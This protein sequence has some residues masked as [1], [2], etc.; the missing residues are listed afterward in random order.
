M[1]E[2]LRRFRASL[3][4][5][6]THSGG[7]TLFVEQLEAR[8]NPTT[9]VTSVVASG[10]AITAG[11]GDLRAGQAAVLTVNFSAVVTVVSTS[12]LPT[13]TLSD[14]AVAAYAGGSGSTALTFGYT[15]APGQN[16]SDLAVTAF[17]LNGS[18]VNA[19]LTGAVTNPAGIL[20]I[21]TTPPTVAM[22]LVGAASQPIGVTSLQYAVTFSELVTNVD[23]SAFSLTTT[24]MNGV[25]ITSVTQ[26]ADAAH[27]T[28]TVAAGTGSGTIGLNIA[29]ANIKDLAGNGFG[30]G[31]F[32]STGVSPISDG[33]TEPESIAIADVNGDGKP[34]LIIANYSS[35][36]VSVLLG[37]GTGSFTPATG[38]PFPVG[39]NPSSVAVAD[40]NGDGKLDIVTSNHGSNNVSVLLGTGTGSFTAAIGSPL[41]LATGARPS[42][43]AIADVNGDGKADL[44]VANYGLNSVT[45]FP[46][47]G[48]GT[49]PF[50]SNNAVSFSLG[51]TSVKAPESV[52]V[53]DVNGDGK[54]DIIT[55]NYGSYSTDGTNGSVSVLLGTGTV[56]INIGS[57]SAA[58]GSPF[59]IVGP[60][61]F[62]VAVA[63]VS[64]DGKPDIVTA[65]YNGGV[66]VLLGTGTGSF[67][68]ATGSPFPVSVHPL[69]V[70]IADVNGDG[71]PD[72]VTAN[73]GSNSVSV[74]LGT[75]AG[76]FSAAAGSPIGVNASSPYAAAVA[77]VNGDGRLDIISANFGSGSV[78]VLPGSVVTQVGPVYTVNLSPVLAYV[79]SDWAS[80]AA[81]SVLT[82]ADPTVTGNQTATIG[83]NAFG[84]LQAA[85]TKLASG[86][87]LVLF[88]GTAAT[89]YSLSAAFAGN[90]TLSV[91]TGT[92]SVSGAISGG[93]LTKTGTGTLAL[94]GVDNYTGGT[95]VST[96][97][98][99]V[100]GSIA[101]GA[102]V[103]AGATLGGSGSVSGAVTSAGVI[104][105]GNAAGTVGTLSAGNLTL[106]PGTL[107]LDLLSTASYDSV[108]VTTAKLS[109]ATLSLNVG[110][111][112]SAGT[113][114]ILTVA[115]TAGG[116][117]GFFN[118]LP[119]LG[120][121][122][123]GGIPFT[124]N[125]AGGDGNDI[126]LTA[127][128]PT[129]LSTILN[130]GLTYI[131]N[132]AV[133]HQHSM[134][135]NVVYSFNQAIA[136]STTNFAAD[137]HQRHHL[138]PE[139]RPRLEQ[140]RHGL[141]GHLHR[142]RRQHGDPLDRRRRIRPRPE[143]SDRAREQHLR[144]LPAVGR[145]GRQR[146]GQLGR[147]LDL[148]IDVPAWNF[149]PG[150]FRSGRPRRQ[151]QDRL[152]R[153]LGIR[154]QFPAFAA[155]HDP[156]ELTTSRSI[157]ASQ[158]N[159]GIPVYTRTWHAWHVSEP[160]S[161][162]FAAQPS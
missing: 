36:N 25:S 115:G 69:S 140:R 137:R 81:G 40:V 129:I 60:G 76:S 120:T 19:T 30:G 59:A 112:I 44:V 139:C 38:S 133:S 55:A 128:T 105:P 126:V 49:T 125:Y 16:T 71:K 26:G 158:T 28:V 90:F 15:V 39:A 75:G 136:L 135:E 7:R 119:N 108:S 80:L 8:I 156:A 96:G 159:G 162:G 121:I 132:T 152:G 11:A 150:V 20:Q 149:R 65:N 74:L 79:N 3:G 83:Q 9:S 131:N 37:T 22:T 31:S 21:D 32:N 134:V 101:T 85:A 99:L 50:V 154:V 46:G 104:T 64:G 138:R 116:V 1:R 103:A 106:G 73:S 29:G 111:G 14:G 87:T 100:N 88:P 54:P 92:A 146:R 151:R 148:R 95:T 123:V 42:S 68:A 77:D 61:P 86:G 48:T 53:A 33:G 51:G 57:F 5:G 63:D 17:S 43:V 141:D 98:L 113:F 45:V 12:G 155:E 130:G 27:Y 102:T 147:L 114:T 153:L 122:T 142:H 157:V 82:D 70:A 144:L 56:S 127:S 78:T 10:L 110:A 66:T 124:I 143:R 52:V 91:P 62:S 2:W 93:S 160:R 89:P 23:A 13:L 72:I 117:S 34:D 107:A 58:T 41:S 4:T 97:T 161:R 109:G 67:S 24:G 6:R 94:S 35:N 84:T 145:H 18:T 118:S 47:L